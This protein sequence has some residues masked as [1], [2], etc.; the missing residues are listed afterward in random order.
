MMF[1]LIVVYIVCLNEILANQ[2]LTDKTLMD[3]SIPD[4]TSGRVS[5]ILL[6][7]LNQES[8]V[9]FSMVQKIQ[10]LEKDVID[11]KNSTRYTEK[12]L[13]DVLKELQT[14]EE[15]HQQIRRENLKLQEDLHTL[16]E[17]LDNI[18]ENVNQSI[19][20]LSDGISRVDSKVLPR[21]CYDILKKYPN[22]KGKDG[23]YT[24][25]TGLSVASVYCDMT[26]D[27]GGWTVLQKRTDGSTDFYRIW[28]EYKYGFGDPKENYWIGNDAI[29]ALTKDQDQELRVDLQ[30]F[31]GDT[32]YA[33]YFTFY[34]GNEA[35]KYQLTVSGYT[36]NAGDSLGPHNGM[37]FSTKDQDND[38]ASYNCA[39]NRHG[40]W[41][42]SACTNSN[43]N[44]KYALSA[45]TSYKSPFWYRWTNEYRALQRTV[46]MIRHKRPS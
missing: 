3:N 40:A 26:T 9:R 19:S 16:N 32:A 37:R 5:N 12:R 46:M 44:G 1:P 30:R 4:T 42:Y 43:L 33:E 14:S 18:R 2:S 45:V 41:W 10:N 31:N 27:G 23:V 25:F 24:I 38:K 28:D 34:I 7:I 15:W 6:G 20:Q 29:H 8:L 36:G 39:I 17:T 13:N 22:V 35:D 21:Y 11:N